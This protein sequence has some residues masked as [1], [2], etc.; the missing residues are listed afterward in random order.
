MLHLLHQVLGGHLQGEFGILD[1]HIADHLSKRQLAVLTDALPYLAQFLTHLFAPGVERLRE[2]LH[3]RDATGHLAAHLLGQRSR[4]FQHLVLLLHDEFL[5]G[6]TGLKVFQLAGSPLHAVFDAGNLGIVGN[7][8]SEAVGLTERQSLTAN[9]TQTVAGVEDGVLA[10][11]CGRPSHCLPT[12]GKLALLLFVVLLQG[13]IIV[14]IHVDERLV[15]RL[16][17]FAIIV[18]VGH[19]FVERGEHGCKGFAHTLLVGHDIVNEAGQVGG[20]ARVNTKQTTGIHAHHLRGQSPHV[21]GVGH[22]LGA[23]GQLLHHLVV[24]VGDKTQLHQLIAKR[25]LC[26]LHIF[27]LQQNLVNLF[28]H[29]G[30]A[31]LD[32]QFVLSG[33][34]QHGLRERTRI[35][36]VNTL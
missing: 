36:I 29:L 17:L 35:E 1:A 19:P 5:R 8:V 12:L 11:L 24:A 20:V 25:A 32:V 34:L 21:V 30:L 3:L 10:L 16:H 18:G 31:A 26:L 27:I 14:G 2:R 23:F 13:F 9:L 15:E 33:I 7:G 22:N 6:I 4:L 28:L